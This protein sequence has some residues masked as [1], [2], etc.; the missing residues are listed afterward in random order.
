MPKLILLVL[1]AMTASACVNLDVKEKE[2]DCHKSR[3][4]LII[5]YIET[6]KPFY[7]ETICEEKAKDEYCM[8]VA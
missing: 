1:L 4:N 5:K 3:K 6:C 2:Y 8:E 7:N